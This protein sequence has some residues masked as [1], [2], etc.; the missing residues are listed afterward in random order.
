MDR[1]SQIELF[2]PDTGD[3]TPADL[4]RIAERLRNLLPDTEVQTAWRGSSATHGADYWPEILL[5]IAG[6]KDLIDTTVRVII[7]TKA[8]EAILNR[9]GKLC[10]KFVCHT[11][12]TTGKVFKEVYLERDNDPVVKRLEDDEEDDW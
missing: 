12:A 9:M 2:S 3:V 8:T 4:N 1:R 6:D 5:W 10:V 7:V 11:S